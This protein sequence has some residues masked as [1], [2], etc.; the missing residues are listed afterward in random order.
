MEY[1]IGEMTYSYDIVGEGE[2]VLLL[3][4]FTGSKKSWK[5]LKAALANDYK[6]IT[7]DLPGHGSTSTIPV[8]MEQ[9]CDHLSV[10]LKAIKVEQAHII[11]YSMGGR[12]ALSF[13]MMYSDQV[14]SLTLESSSPGL[15]TGEERRTRRANDEKLANR[16]LEKGLKTFV[17]FWENIP[18]FDSQKKLPLE[19]QQRIR[20]G[21]LNQRPEG[22]ANSLKYMGT[23]AQPSWWQNLSEINFPTLLI[24]GEL[25]EKFVRINE[26]MARNIKK[27]QFEIVKEAGHAVH[28]EKPKQYEKLIVHFLN[29]NKD[30][31]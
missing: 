25:D 30:Q 27:V 13:A 21:R 11:G 5:D 19:T 12:V 10:F 3:H 2:A 31:L 14:A 16:I 29:E 22:L 6:V 26:R 28:L 20:T 9:C 7:I 1:V 17:N 24:V 15:A 4:G 8:T 18:L 23:G